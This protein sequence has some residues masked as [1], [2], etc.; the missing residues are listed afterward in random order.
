MNIGAS[1]ERRTHS[2][3]R[4]EN[5]SDSDTDI[6]RPRIKRPG[7]SAGSA[8]LP[9]TK[10]PSGATARSENDSDSD[11]DIVQPKMKRPAG[12]SVL[13]KTKRPSGATARSENDSDSDTVIVQP[14]MKRPAGSTVLPKM[15]R[16]SGSTARPENNSDSNTDV[17]KTKVKRCR[18]SEYELGVLFASVG[19]FITNKKMPPGKAV[20]ELAK[21]LTNRTPAQVRTQ[22]NNFVTGKLLPR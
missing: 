4:S 22:I 7:Q 12:S 17:G 18:W 21:K 9:K 1:V 16:P 20:N 5:N 6:V 13:P 14:K 3:A 15:E 8:V 2:T 10:R 11:T 19:N